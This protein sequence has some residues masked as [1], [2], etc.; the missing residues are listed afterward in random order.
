M[1]KQSC[2]DKLHPQMSLESC[3]LNYEMKALGFSL[4]SDH[5]I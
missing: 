4:L 5:V 1:W 2:D 3:K